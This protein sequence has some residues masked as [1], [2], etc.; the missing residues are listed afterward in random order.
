G[1]IRHLLVWGPQIGVTIDDP[2]PSPLP[3][4]VQVG[5]HGSAGQAHQDLVFYVSKDGQRIVQ[6]NVYDIALN[7][8][9]TELDKLK[10]ELQPSL[11]TPGAPVVIVEFSDFQCA[12][13]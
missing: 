8:F 2:K 13:C 7:P 1:Y 3:G 6:G 12:Y 4:F 10:T 5:V 11:G 9:K